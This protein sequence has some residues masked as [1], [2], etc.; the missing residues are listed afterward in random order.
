MEGKQPTFVLFDAWVRKSNTLEGDE[1]ITELAKRYFLSHGPATEKDFAG[2]T[3]LPLTDARKGIRAL[4]TRLVREVI[5]GTEYIMPHTLQDAFKPSVA[6]LPG[7]DEYM[8]GYKD[9][10]A[11]LHVDHSGKIVPGNN[12]MFLSTVVVDGQVIGTWKRVIR[13]KT[14][15]IT[16][17]VFPGYTIDAAH[18]PLLVEAAER[19]GSFVSREVLLEI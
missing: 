1:A 13:A 4:D 5:E 11:A 9:R 16:P 10:T 14:V 6:L 12:G 19:Y 2:W 3:G 18:R 17:S 7:F 15:A 8:L